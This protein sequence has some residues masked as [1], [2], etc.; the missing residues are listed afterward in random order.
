M[1]HSAIDRKTEGSA[2]RNFACACLDGFGT[3]SVGY[4][5]VAAAP[6][7]ESGAA[8]SR[9]GATAWTAAEQGRAGHTCKDIFG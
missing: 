5:I 8:S 9:K 6:T 3:D 2:G 7:G 1:R 4:D